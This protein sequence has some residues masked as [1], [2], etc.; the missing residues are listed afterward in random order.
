MVG[1]GAAEGAFCVPTTDTLGAAYRR[2][3]RCTF[4]AAIAFATAAGG[5]GLVP[6]CILSVEMRELAYIWISR[7]KN[8][9]LF[10]TLSSK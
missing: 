3:D 1:A 4:A 10:R 6:H 7:A 5:V 8:L 9:I 2:Q